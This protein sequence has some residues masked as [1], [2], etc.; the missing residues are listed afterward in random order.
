F[1][2]FKDVLADLISYV[3]ESKKITDFNVGSVTRTILEAVAAIAEEV[4]HSLR[5]FVFKFF[6]STSEGEWLDKRLNDLGMERNQGS[7]A[8][9][10][11]TFGRDTPSPLSVY[12][13]AGTIATLQADTGELSYI[14]Q[15]DAV[16][17]IGD[18]AVDVKAEAADPGTEYN[19]LPDTLLKQAGIAITGIEWVKIKL[20]GG[21]ADIES[22]EEYKSR[23]PDYFDS[24]A[25]GTG[26]SIAYAAQ[27]VTGVKS[28]TMRENFPDKGWFTLYIDDGSGVANE[29]LLHS[30]RAVVEDYRAFTVMYI[31]DTAKLKM[32]SA[33]LKLF[34]SV[35]INEEA[36]K[37]SVQED[38]VKYINEL[39]MGAPLYLADLIYLAKNIEGVE[40]VRIISPVE[41]VVI[42][43]DELLR[44]NPAEVVIE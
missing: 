35:G 5:L 19:L 6:I 44:T 36:V 30:V 26:K 34:Y 12:I 27:N 39:K 43:D 20:I 29:A 41:D 17:N 15:Q 37:K 38:I 40:N 23:V 9:G 25:R 11:L 21:G 22:D 31:I 10:L 8:F 4:W 32:F 13:P 16:L 3:G 33:Q 18:L 24:L 28:V 14:T 7:K 2:S 42:A 1:K